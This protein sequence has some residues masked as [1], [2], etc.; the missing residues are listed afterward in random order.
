MMFLIFLASGSS[1]SFTKSRHFL[2]PIIR[3]FAPGITE[4]GIRGVIAVV[5]KS[6]HVGEY[7]VLSFLVWRALRKPHRHDQRPWSWKE[8]LFVLLGAALYAATDEWHQSL[9]PNRQGAVADVFIDISGAA[10]ALAIVWFLHR[11]RAKVSR[12]TNSPRPGNSIS[13]Q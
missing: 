12:A 13:P 5:R 3:W 6:A 8:P 7:A 1:A 9:V 4:Q 11:R 2:E 10:L